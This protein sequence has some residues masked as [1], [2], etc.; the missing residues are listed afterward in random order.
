M[1]YT[2]NP[3]DWEALARQLGL[4]RP[5]GES[6][7][8]DAAMRAIEILLGEDRL[9]ASVDFYVAYRPG[10]ATKSIGLRPTTRNEARRSSC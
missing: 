4:L 6:S 2:A 3:I 7:G 10:R 9:R 8:S 5:D 1:N